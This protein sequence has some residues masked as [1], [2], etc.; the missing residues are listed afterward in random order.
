MLQAEVEVGFPWIKRYGMYL[1][2]YLLD[3]KDLRPYEL[4]QITPQVLEIF[5]VLK[6]PGER[7]RRPNQRR[8]GGW[9]VLNLKA[10]NR[11]TLLGK[12]QVLTVSEPLK[13]ISSNL[14]IEFTGQASWAK[15]R[16]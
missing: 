5:G 9:H 10:P 15:A 12:R 3:L 6:H 11:H 7:Q 1:T 13:V 8:C 14:T 16:E 4:N 2:T